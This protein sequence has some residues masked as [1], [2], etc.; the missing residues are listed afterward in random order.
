MNT[1]FQL[2]ISI[3]KS[4]FWH[5]KSK[6]GALTDIPFSMSLWH[7]EYIYIYINSKYGLC[8]DESYCID[9]H[10]CPCWN[11]KLGVVGR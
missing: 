4:S 2:I 9:A 3:E 5:A 6:I 7:K 10:V 8:F 1:I 11:V